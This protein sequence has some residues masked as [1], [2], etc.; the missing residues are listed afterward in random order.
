MGRHVIQNPPWLQHA[1][2]RTRHSPIDE[3][4]RKQPMLAHSPGTE[5]TTD[6]LMVPLP[7]AKL[8]SNSFDFPWRHWMTHCECDILVSLMTHCECDILVSL[9][10]LAHNVT[11]LSCSNCRRVTRS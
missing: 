1:Q 8:T 3:L 11:M 5:P 7:S 4:W 9:I 2:M 10:L 6:I